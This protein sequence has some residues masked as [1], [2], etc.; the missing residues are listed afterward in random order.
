MRNQK[1]PCWNLLAVS[2]YLFIQFLSKA[3]DY[4]SL[5]LPQQTD[6]HLS[7]TTSVLPVKFSSSEGTERC[8]TLQSVN[9]FAKRQE[10]GKMQ[11]RDTV[12]V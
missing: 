10:R 3:E 2:N 11:E 8:E 1:F 12:K 4:L 7:K 9:N 5:N 6:E